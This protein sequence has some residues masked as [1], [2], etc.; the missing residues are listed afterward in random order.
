MPHLLLNVSPFAGNTFCPKVVNLEYS[1]GATVSFTMVAFTD[2]ICERQTRIHFTHGELV[3]DMSTFR[4]VDFRTTQGQKHHPAME[5]RTGHG[6]GDIGLIRSFVRAVK[7]GKQDI[8]GTDVEEV[9][10]S[11]LTVFA[12][13]QSRKEG[14]VVSCEEYEKQVRA[15]MM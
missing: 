12:A 4:T 13:E 15:S 11:H 1:N 14:R 7:E 2:L 5:D 3:G 10:K 6:G 8:L 9:L